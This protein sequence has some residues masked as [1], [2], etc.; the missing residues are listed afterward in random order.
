MIKGQVLRSHSVY[1]FHKGFDPRGFH[2]IP[3]I[4]IDFQTGTDNNAVSSR[5][6]RLNVA[7]TRSGV[8]KN[9]H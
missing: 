9:R 4:P 1:G 8:E 7:E 2:R 3:G 5:E 6:K